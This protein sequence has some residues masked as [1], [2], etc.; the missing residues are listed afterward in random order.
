MN[1]RVDVG[2]LVKPGYNVTEVGVFPADWEVSLLGLCLQERP[3]SV[4]TR[5][6][7]GSLSQ[8][9]PNVVDLHRPR[10]DQ[11]IAAVAHCLVLPGVIGRHMDRGQV[12]STGNLA[13]D[14][15]VALVR[16]DAPRT[17]TQRAHQGR[18]NDTH[19]V[20][21]LQCYVGNVEGLGTGFHDHPTGWSAG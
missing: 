20:T 5:D 18:R 6:R 10:R 17:D 11:P 12:D 1:R 13:E 8:P 9:A 14:S 2:E 7:G 21:V 19:L 3:R 15:C 16:L 4:A